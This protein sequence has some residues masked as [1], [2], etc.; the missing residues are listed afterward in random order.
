MTEAA[1]PNSFEASREL[2]S[3]RQSLQ[4]QSHRGFVPHVY[5]T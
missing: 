5:Q 1:G 2:N 3:D 4:E